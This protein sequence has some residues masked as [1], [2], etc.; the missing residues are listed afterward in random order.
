MGRGRRVVV[1]TPEAPDPFGNAASRWYYVLLK[2][3]AAG[4]HDVRALCAWTSA[5]S[6]EA[7]RAR[8]AG[9]GVRLALFAYP[10]RAGSWRRKWATARRPYSYFIGPDLQRAVDTAAAAGY[11][12]LH[13]EQ[14]WAGY[15]GLARPRTVL[16]VHHLTSLDLRGAGV[17]SARGLLD[18]ALMGRTE[19]W[20]LRR[21]GAIR[22]TTS[23]LATEILRANPAAFVATVPIAVDL[24]LYP[25]L[26][27]RDE[28][29]TVGFIGSA[30]WHIGHAAARR[31]LTRI[32]P[33]VRARRPAA[34]LLL[35]GWGMGQAFGAHDGRDGVTVR[36]DVPDARRDFF[37]RA[38]LFAYPLERG[39]G[40][41]VKVLEAMAYGLPV[42]AT[43]EG[44]EGVIDVP[45]SP[46]A[47]PDDDAAFA[48][49][50]ADLLAAP[51]ERRR[52]A[53]AGR[54][55]VEAH[56]SPAATIPR[57]E[58]LHAAVADGGGPGPMAR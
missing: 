20:M 58:A 50:V 15:L 56:F 7:A 34:R 18:R 24:D 40:M 57:I 3:L 47:A 27:A 22:A 11:D 1:V 31:L 2:G 46:P 37:E 13:L 5:A 21:F 30:T 32:W 44:L 51:A 9:S 23:R 12:V 19:R 4:G 25:R 26:A 49:R 41:K 42:V 35:A 6:A 17:R 45:G 39:S 10:D 8:L 16:S 54:R 53:D 48:A 52:L 33:R 43:R 14:M 36:G 28:G 38:A 55:L 29:E